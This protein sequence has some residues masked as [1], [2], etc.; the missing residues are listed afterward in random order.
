MILVM[1]CSNSLW[2]EIE[3]R[4]YIKTIEPVVVAL[5]RRIMALDLHILDF[6]H[7]ALPPRPNH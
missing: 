6:F 1:G 5:G 3:V 7:L 4:L 2:N